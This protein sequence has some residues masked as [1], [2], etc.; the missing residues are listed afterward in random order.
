[1]AVEL[2]MAMRQVVPAVVLMALVELM[3]CLRS[4]C[5]LLVCW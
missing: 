5:Q 4:D 2:L 3:N 1:M